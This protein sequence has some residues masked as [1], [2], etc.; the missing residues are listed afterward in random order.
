MAH[1]RVSFRSQDRHD[2][3]GRRGIFDSRLR[4]PLHAYLLTS[5]LQLEELANLLY[6]YRVDTLIW[7]NQAP[8]INIA[9]DSE[10]HARST[11]NDIVRRVPSLTCKSHRKGHVG[12]SNEITYFV[13]CNTTASNTHPMNIRTERQRPL[14]SFMAAGIGSSKLQDTKSV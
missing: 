1:E 11:D 2:I 10:Q 8:I 13:Q 14:T 12:T 5:K 4:G 3:V 6:S 9:L 7:D